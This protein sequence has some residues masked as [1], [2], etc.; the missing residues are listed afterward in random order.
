[1]VSAGS[2]RAAV[3]VPGGGYTADGPLL[4]YA[5]LAVERRGEVMRTASRRLRQSPGL[6]VMAGWPPRSRP[7][8]MRPR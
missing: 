7:L 8:S 5:R 1:V 3:L 4:M 2:G 6:R